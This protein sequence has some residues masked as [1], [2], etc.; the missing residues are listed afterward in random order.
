MREYSSLNL[1][2]KDLKRGTL[3]CVQLVKYYLSNIT[4]KQHL[5]ALNEVYEQ[6]AL[7]CALSVDR[8]IQNGNAGKLAGLVV[9]IKDVISHKDHS[10]SAGSKI[11]NSFEAQYHATVVEKLLKE[12]AIIIGRNN[13]DEF[14]MGSSNE[15]SAYGH[16]LNDLDNERVPGGSSGGSAVAVQSEM[17]L[18]SIGSDTGGSV[19][20]P[21]AFCGLVGFKPTYSRISRHG[22]FAYAS[23]FDCIG[24]LAKNVSDVASVLEVVSGK[25][26]HDNT[27]SSEPVPEY[28]VSIE[29]QERKYKIAYLQDALS[30]KGLNDEIK[31][32]TVQLIDNLSSREHEVTPVVFPLME[33]VLP[34][35]YLLTM[36]EA[37]S[38]LSR[39]DGVKYGYRATEVD[40]LEELYKKSRTQG[41]GEE[42][43]RRIMLGTFVLSANYYDAYYKKAQKVR[44]LIREATKRILAQNDFI[45][46]PTTATTA[47]KIGEKNADPLTMYLEDLFTVQASVCGLPAISVP[48]GLDKDNMPVGIQVMANDF[49]E[50]NLLAFSNYLMKLD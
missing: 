38:N 36:A 19:R 46:G 20:Q 2:Q 35:Y 28:S 44:S 47:F 13:C 23:S 14:G 5:N 24:I 8:K 50:A 10:V 3:S 29:K 6:E 32:Q 9:T 18:V 45:I 41:F 16:V 7:D 26:E 4:S 48:L 27:S 22:L 15:N 40:N 39:Y 49:E 42:V 34:T 12:D 43:K 33:Y 11:L 21:A 30:S 31:S 37:S 17:C 1:I 25:D